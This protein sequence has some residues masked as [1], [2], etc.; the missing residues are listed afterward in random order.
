MIDYLPIG[1]IVKLKEGKVELL[2][3]GYCKLI[4]QDKIKANDYVACIYPAGLIDMKTLI[5]FKHDQ[6][7]EIVHQGI[8]TDDYLKIKKAL[9]KENN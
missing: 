4:K 1:S 6:I 9:N 7:E 3:I 2:I 5:A 8:K